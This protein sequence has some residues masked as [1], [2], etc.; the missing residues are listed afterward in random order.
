MRPT[1]LCKTVERTR[2]F[3]YLIMDGKSYYL[4]SQSYRYG[5]HQ[6]FSKGV[7]LNLALDHTR[8]KRDKAITRTMEKIPVYIKYL[9]KE[10]DITV[11]DQTQ[12]KK[13][14]CKYRKPCCA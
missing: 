5:V 8:A 3:F 4:F 13:K 7:P 1:I 14:C 11:L 10:Y 12:K 6:Y 2:H 9:E